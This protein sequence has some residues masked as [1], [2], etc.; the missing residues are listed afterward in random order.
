MSAGIHSDHEGS[1]WILQRLQSEIGCVKAER[2]RLHRQIEVHSTER[3]QLKMALAAEIDLR[4]MVTR[5]W[6]ESRGE[7]RNLHESISGP[8]STARKPEEIRAEIR[9]LREELVRARQEAAALRA[10]LHEL[11]RADRGTHTR[12]L[13][14]LLGQ[15]RRWLVSSRQVDS[16]AAADRHAS[17]PELSDS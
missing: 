9:A 17:G 7:V 4:R 5:R 14:W 16:Y 1:A 6:A 11:T 2:D 15:S 12:R 13:R 8:G 3:A 10:Q